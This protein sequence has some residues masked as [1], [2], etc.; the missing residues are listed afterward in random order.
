M[1]E[2]PRDADRHFTLGLAQSEQDMEGAIASFRTVLELA[3]RHTLARYNLALVL[4]RAD[5]LSEA[6]A[7][8]ERALAI[9]PRPEA[10]YTMG[11]IYWHQGKLDRAVSAT[12]CATRRRSASGPAQ[13]GQL[14]LIRANRAIVGDWVHIFGGSTVF[15]MRAGYTYFLELSRADEGCSASTR[16]SWASR[17][18][19]SAS[20]RNRCSRSSTSTNTL[21]LS[22]GQGENAIIWSIQPNISGRRGD[23]TTSAPASI[24]S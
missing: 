14:P 1:A 23:A 16:P 22:R 20:S 2:A 10:Y 5:R 3:P 24:S 21:N 11:V 18:A 19:W 15:N 17:R 7:E 13:N 4:R 8:L 6:L 9:E 12:S